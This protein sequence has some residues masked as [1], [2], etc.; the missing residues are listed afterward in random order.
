M[1]VLKIGLV[2]LLLALT[3]ASDVHA[4]TYTFSWN[5]C[6]LLPPQSPVYR[7]SP[8]IFTFYLDRRFTPPYFYEREFEYM[9]LTMYWHGTKNGVP[10]TPPGGV[11]VSTNNPVYIFGRQ[12]LGVFVNPSNGGLG[13]TY[14][15]WLELKDAKGRTY[16][17]STP[18]QVTLL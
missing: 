11:P 16:C 1:K 9:P 5:I 8:Y 7:G 15:R 2:S 6:T 13:G 3:N 14:V 12:D 17:E 18:A 4:A 10:D